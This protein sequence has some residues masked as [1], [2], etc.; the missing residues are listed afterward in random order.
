[1]FE[2][3]IDRKRVYASDKKMVEEEKVRNEGEECERKRKAEEYEI[4]EK[5]SDEN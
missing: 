2:Y 4:K 3:P 5:G 1:M